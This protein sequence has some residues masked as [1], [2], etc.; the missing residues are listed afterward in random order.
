MRRAYTAAWIAGLAAF[1]IGYVSDF[2]PEPTRYLL[3]L[4]LIAIA[5]VPVFI[6]KRPRAK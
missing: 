5:V 2:N 4:I 3:G 6:V 1:A